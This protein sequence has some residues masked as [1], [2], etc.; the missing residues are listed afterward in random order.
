MRTLYFIEFLV[1][2]HIRPEHVWVDQFKLEWDNSVGIPTPTLT[3]T[4]I[5]NKEG[6]IEQIANIEK[7]EILSYRRGTHV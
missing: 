5:E 6:K 2:G 4:V 7:F 3:F 1:H